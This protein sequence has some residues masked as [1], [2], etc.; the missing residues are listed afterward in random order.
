MWDSPL[1]VNYWQGC[2]GF[3]CNTGPYYYPPFLP[4]F[5]PSFYYGAYPY[6]SSYNPVFGFTPLDATFWSPAVAAMLEPS[7]SPVVQSLQQ[8]A[9]QNAGNTQ[10]Y[11]VFNFTS[12]PMD[13]QIA[14]RQRGQIAR[15]TLDQ[16]NSTLIVT[17]DPTEELLVSVQPAD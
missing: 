3:G 16:Q 2:G 14:S 9:L 7:I 11:A 17:I 1:G 12:L 8:T 15:Q 13:V 4:Q 6:F 10:L 5:S